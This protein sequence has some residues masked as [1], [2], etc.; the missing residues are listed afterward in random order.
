M[1][2]KRQRVEALF[3]PWRDLLPELQVLVAT[4]AALPL[5]ARVML[6]WTAKHEYALARV[7]NNGIL[8]A[9]W[10]AT[11][12]GW[13]SIVEAYVG[14]WKGGM[15]SSDALLRLINDTYFKGDYATPVW[16][17][18]VAKKR[19][20]AWEGRPTNTVG[21][22][23]MFATFA[24]TD[25]AELFLGEKPAPA[26]KG[27]KHRFLFWLT[28][29]A[30]QYGNDLILKWLERTGQLCLCIPRGA[31]SSDCIER[32]VCPSLKQ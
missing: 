22:A 19:L 11:R 21:W 13:R 32:S 12:L 28:Y 8:P 24:D 4:T 16:L 10:E 31:L 17:Y 26:D 1:R 15:E 5:P 29:Y 20:V 18:T 2:A 25:V 6:S 14:R 30:T 7:P 27:A 3:A 9:H 23:K